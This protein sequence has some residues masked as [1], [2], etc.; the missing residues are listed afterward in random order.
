MKYRKGKDEWR[1]I[2]QIK[3]KESDKC[4]QDWYFCLDTCIQVMPNS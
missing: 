1:Q 3:K 4:G 2:K